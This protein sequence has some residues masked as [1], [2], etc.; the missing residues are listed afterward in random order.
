MYTSRA[1]VTDVMEL[2]SLSFYIVRA[3]A[4]FSPLLT[5]NP[6]SIPNHSRYQTA[7]ISPED[8]QLARIDDGF[9]EPVNLITR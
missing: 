8:C 3:G 9:V 1:L 2:V 6:H 4:T 5:L 7:L